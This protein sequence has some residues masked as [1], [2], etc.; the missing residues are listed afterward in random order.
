MARHIFSLFNLSYSAAEYGT[1][2]LCIQAM[3]CGGGERVWN[4]SVAVLMS[5]LLLYC[6]LS[7]SLS[8]FLAWLLFL[9][10][11]F[12]CPEFFFGA[13]CFVSIA[14]QH[15]VSQRVSVRTD[16]SNK[17]MQIVGKEKPNNLF[18]SNIFE[19]AGTVE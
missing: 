11:L 16:L 14:T 12:L 3:W 7:F 17:L 1:N 4:K 10:Y 8:L 5:M 2:A 15:F 13:E 6:D 19:E 18:D 9:V